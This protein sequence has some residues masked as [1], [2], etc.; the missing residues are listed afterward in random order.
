M[1]GGGTENDRQRKIKRSVYLYVVVLWDRCP[2]K[3]RETDTPSF[4]NTTTYP[5]GGMVQGTSGVEIR[6]DGKCDVRDMITA[7]PLLQGITL[8][9]KALL[10]DWKH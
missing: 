9:Q 1:L 7:E 6:F 3:A 2:H 10:V 5:I 8:P 4:S